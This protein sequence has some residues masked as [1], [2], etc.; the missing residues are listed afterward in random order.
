MFHSGEVEQG[1]KVT[2]SDKKAEATLP[3][4]IHQL[5]HWF[6]NPSYNHLPFPLIKLWKYYKAELFKGHLKLCQYH[7]G[8]LYLGHAFDVYVNIS[9]F[10]EE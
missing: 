4:K 10:N 6:N 2:K 7:L 8:K 9:H 5:K 3:A 1:G